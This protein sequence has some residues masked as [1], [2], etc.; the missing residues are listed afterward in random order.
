MPANSEFCVLATITKPS[1]SFT[2]LSKWLMKARM[3][4]EFWWVWKC[5]SPE[6]LTVHRLPETGEET[7][8]VGVPRVVDLDVGVAILCDV[9]ML[10]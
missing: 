7:I 4:L 3:M 5:C 8:S 1:G 10:V 6:Y 9:H 2:I